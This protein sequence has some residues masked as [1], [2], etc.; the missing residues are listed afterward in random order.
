MVALLGVD[1]EPEDV[2]AVNAA[3][4][5]SREA[6]SAGGHGALDAVVE[7][8]VVVESSPSF[9]AAARTDAGEDT[10]LTDASVSGPECWFAGVAALE[11][12]RNPVRAARALCG[13]PQSILAGDGAL[14]WARAL[15]L[16]QEQTVPAASHPAAASASV[17][18]SAGA[19]QPEAPI[20]EW[21]PWEWLVGDPRRDGGNDG[22]APNGDASEPR[23]AIGA[24]AVLVRDS[25][26]AFAGALSSAGPDFGAPGRVGDV[27]IPGAALF[28][29]D[30]G[31]VAISGY[32]G[33]L[34]RLGLARAVYGQLAQHAGAVDA[35]EWA[36]AQVP[37]GVHMGIIV[38]DAQGFAAR[39]TTEMAWAAQ[40]A[41]QYASSASKPARAAGR[42]AA[43]GGEP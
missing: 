36:L 13:A 7:G 22:A 11:R 2:E 40:V 12:V 26:G 3:V 15:G 41:D 4:T 34:A 39:S 1:S 10:L 32:Q 42:G 38:L 14:T 30:V 33:H 18:P 25:G 43:K 9:V 21:T 35:A 28:V 23:P 37:D 27:V 6:L 19:G 16:T 5:A 8:M 20:P 31:A 29:G 24:A 17:P